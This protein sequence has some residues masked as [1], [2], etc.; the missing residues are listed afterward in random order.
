[1]LYIVRISGEI[2]IKSAP[3]RASFQRRLAQNVSAALA[4]QK[5]KGHFKWDGGR[6]LLESEETGLVPVLSRLFG[7][8]SVSPVIASCAAVLE[9]IV[10]K[11][12]ALY[13]DR[14][15]TGSFAVQCRRSG[16]HEFTSMDV[17]QT[18]GAA[19]RTPHNRVNLSSQ[20]DVAIGVEVRNHHAHF[21]HESIP[22]PGGL[23]LGTGGRALCL[24]SGGFDSAAA[25]WKM[26]KRGVEVDFA[27]CSVASAEYED[28]AV[29]VTRT[30][31]ERWA[32]GS[33]PHMYAIPF[34]DVV[35]ELRAKVQPRFVQVILKRMFY[36]AAD[37]V[38]RKHNAL[39]LVTGEAIGQVSSQT[40]MNL[41]AIESASSRPVLRPLISF[42]KHEIIA[43][44]RYIGTYEASSGIEEYCQ[45]VPDK[46]STHTPLGVALSEEAKVDLGILAEAVEQTKLRSLLPELPMAAPS[47]GVELNTAPENAVWIDCRSEAEYEAWHHP[48]AVWHEFYELMDMELAKDKTYVI[49]CEQNLQS[50]VAAEK[51]Q[52]Q[53]IQAFYLLGGVALF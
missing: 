50:A 53:G 34:G 28:S 17:N 7:V 35:K 12:V 25:A 31:V 45:L 8:Q 21:F 47:Y 20:P 26:M 27:F 44:C 37:A 5:A 10:E 19:L 46:P 51:F 52:S 9:T 24:I 18:L 29:A 42:D 33:T 3:V 32:Y 40:L 22:G 48:N 16:K 2:T 14:V 11:G 38:A 6:L 15:T 43:L 36:R 41:C 13:Q 4:T 49:Y 1:M 23:P 30:L 39:A